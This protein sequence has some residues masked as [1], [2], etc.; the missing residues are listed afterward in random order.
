MTHVQKNEPSLGSVTYGH[1]EN[2]ASV[3]SA[4]KSGYP[5][6]YAGAKVQK[7]LLHLAGYEQPKRFDRH[8][9]FRATA[10]IAMVPEIRMHSEI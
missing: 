6:G 4:L 10:Q 8:V 5:S 7:T 9:S 2:F 3:V 1:D